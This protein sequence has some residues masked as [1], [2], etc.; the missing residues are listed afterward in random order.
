VIRKA[1][2]A[3]LVMVG[4]ALAAHWTGRLHLLAGG[5]AALLLIAL[6]AIVSVVQ[7]RRTPDGLEGGL[8]DDT[9]APATSALRDGLGGVA[10]GCFGLALGALIYS[11][12]LPP[13]YPLLVGDCP[14][15]LPR[16]AIYEET[17]SWA[18][19]VA[20]IDGRLASPLDRNCRAELAERKARYLIEWSKALPREQA[21][22]KLVE[23][24][25][26]AHDN[27][28]AQF[29]TIAA[30]LREQLQPTSGPTLITPT[31]P[32]SPT[33]RRLPAG[34]S[35]QV[36]GIDLAYFPPTAFVYLRVADAAGQA[37]AGLAPSDIRV[38]DDGQPV[39]G[40][41]LSQFSQQ[42]TPLH[43]ALVIDSSGSM[44]GEP[45]AAAKAGAR[46]FLGLLGPRDQVEIIGF[47]DKAQV[48]QT[49]TADRQLSGQALDLLAANGATA[50]WDALWLAGGDLAGCPGRK[51]VVVLSDGG[52][53]RSRHTQG[54]VIAQARRAGLSVF[55]IGLRSAEYDGPALQALVQAAGGCYSEASGPAQLEEYYRQVAGAIRSEYRLALTLPRQPNGGAH[56]LQLEIGGPQPIAVEQRYQDPQP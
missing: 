13:F 12:A 28:L 17:E 56:L 7:R 53:N 35:A 31:P 48:L 32:P 16:L 19:A 44:G 37:I 33:P 55:V 14:T 49:W 18:H 11:Y 45:L 25:R 50:L 34:A 15:I 36:S 39:T 29:R 43:A 42:P 26:W 52:D 47:S 9:E 22:Q 20:L 41:S 21:E 5:L 30:L 8:D 3:L 38:S 4:A 1:A 40:F 6:A 54:E 24:E 27:N 2:L 23:A 46:T 10:L 51:A